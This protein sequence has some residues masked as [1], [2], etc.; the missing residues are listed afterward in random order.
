MFQQIGG[1][2]RPHRSFLRMG[3]DDRARLFLRAGG[4][5][6]EHLFVLGDAP[7]ARG[8]L[9]DTR[10]DSGIGNALGQLGHK[11]VVNIIFRCS[12][13]PAELEV[14]RRPSPS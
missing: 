5:A 6:E 11:H 7:F 13:K 2:F 4:G 10:L 8:E 12:E 1:L 9:D 3:D 14:R